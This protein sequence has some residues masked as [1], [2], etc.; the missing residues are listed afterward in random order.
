MTTPQSVNALCQEQQSLEE[1]RDQPTCEDHVSQSSQENVDD[2]GEGF[3]S[4]DLDDLDDDLDDLEDELN[5]HDSWDNAS[6]GIFLS[7]PIIASC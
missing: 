4:D 6:G 7:A 3:F 5:D 1:Q 2:Q